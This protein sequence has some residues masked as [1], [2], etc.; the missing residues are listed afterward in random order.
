MR[1]ESPEIR[2]ERSRV[3]FLIGMERERHQRLSAI[4]RAIQPDSSANNENVSTEVLA[5]LNK[6]INERLGESVERVF[7]LLHLIYSPTDIQSV[8]FSFST[9]P[10]LRASAVEFLD[11]LID[12]PLRELVVSLVEEREESELVKEAREEGLSRTEAVH[13][14]LE[15]DDEWLRTIASELAGRWRAEE[16]VW[17]S[18]LA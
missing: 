16:D 11:N 9:R 1:T 10:A 2:F 5:L 8:Y 14:L 13:R 12:P 18:R 7:R 4:R 6:A 15:E 17:S 3:E